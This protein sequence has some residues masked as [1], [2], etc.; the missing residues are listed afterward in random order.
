MKRAEFMRLTDLSEDQVKTRAKLGQLP[1]LPASEGQ[2]NYTPFDAFLVQLTN[3]ITR[4]GHNLRDASEHV[5]SASGALARAWNWI[6]RG[7]EDFHYLRPRT[8]YQ[9]AS[10]AEDCLLGIMRVFEMDVGYAS[11][12]IRHTYF[13]GTAAQIFSSAQQTKVTNTKGQ[14]L[15][16]KD[17]RLESFIIVNATTAWR[18]IKAEAWQHNKDCESG[19]PLID[20]SDVFGDGPQ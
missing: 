1:F 19:A 20:L 5:R 13:V 11:G 8:D 9:S 12:I 10:F 6:E 17:L 14:E 15:F 2:H 18:Y 16:L 4:K 3:E 7:S